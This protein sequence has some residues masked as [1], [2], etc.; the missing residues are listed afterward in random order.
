MHYLLLSN[1]KK[2]KLKG[3]EEKIYYG[4]KHGQ[5]LS[6]RMYFKVSNYITF[7]RIFE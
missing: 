4:I 6:Q 5:K 7:S 1:Y 3:K 2:R